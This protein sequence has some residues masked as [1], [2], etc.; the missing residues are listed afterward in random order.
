MVLAVPLAFEGFR[1]SR[2]LCALLVVASAMDTQCVGI[3]EY[4][5]KGRC[6]SLDRFDH[7]LAPMNSGSCFA[8]SAA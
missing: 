1:S 7:G 6:R 2:L 3:K 8:D 4:M 5:Q